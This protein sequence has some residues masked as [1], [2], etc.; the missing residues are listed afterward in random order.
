VI[1]AEDLTAAVDFINP[2]VA[3]T[4][5]VAEGFGKAESVPMF[6]QV[7]EAAGIDYDA[8][9]A[10]GNEVLSTAI[11][12]GRVNAREYTEGVLQGIVYGA[13]AQQA[14]E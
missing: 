2:Y 5:S 14:N 7:A 13:L 4:N 3:A 10:F 11:E 1:G 9:I 8:L 12:H 6:K